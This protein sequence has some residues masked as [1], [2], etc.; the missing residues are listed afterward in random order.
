MGQTVPLD[1]VQEIGIIT[2]NFTAEYGRADAGVI[3]VTTKSGT[4]EFHGTA[5]E[6][7]RVSDLASNTFNNNAYGLD[8][9]IFVRNQFGYSVGGPVKKNKLFFFSN[10]EWT[11][12]RSAANLTTIVPDPALIAASAPATQAIFSAYGKLAPGASI[13]QTFSRNQL[14][15]NGIG[16]LLRCL[17]QPADAESTIPTA[18]MF[19]LGRLQRAQQLRRRKS[20]ERL[21]QRK[22]SGLQSQRQNARFTLATR[23]KAKWIRREVFPTAL[24]AGYNI[25]QTTFNNSLIVSMTHTFSPR[26]V[27]QSKLDFN[28]FNT[29]QPLPPRWRGARLLSRKCYRA[30]PHWSLQRLPAGR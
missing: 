21:V 14:M 9:P 29:V 19:D 11:R 22:S 28:R 16:S 24:T 7:N 3:N 18:P 30:A 13:L 20:A 2:N 5:Y 4:N 27:S 26:F 6:F 1:S 17:G 8:K 15:R 10:T 12:V 25:G 23:C